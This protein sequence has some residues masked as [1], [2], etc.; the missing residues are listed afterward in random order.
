MLARYAVHKLI[1]YGERPIRE[2]TKAGK[3]LLQ[4]ACLAS[5]FVERGPVESFNEAWQDALARG[6]DW[7]MRALQG[8]MA[9]LSLAPE[10]DD[11]GLWREA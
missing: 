4:A 11:P 6:R 8:K 7:R 3:D 1:V 2:R 10:L 9:L 5:F